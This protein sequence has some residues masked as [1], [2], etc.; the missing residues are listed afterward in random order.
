VFQ[1]S[2]ASLDGT[3]VFDGNGGINY[4]QINTNGAVLAASLAGIS[5][6]QFI[7]LSA[8]GSVTLA[9]TLS[10]TI[11]FVTGTSAA[12]TF[13]GSG[14][15]SYGISF[16]GFG[17]A[18]T[19]TG[20]AQ[21]DAFNIEDSAFTAID[22][23]AGIDYL[24]PTEDGQT[25]DISANAVKID[26]IEAI[27]LNVADNTTVSLVAADI[28]NITST[29]ALYVVGGADDELDA[30]TGWTLIGPHTN[31]A[32]APGVTFTEYLHSGGATLYVD[33]DITLTI[34][35]SENTPPT[36]TSMDILTNEDFNVEIC[37]TTFADAE[38]ESS[39]ADVEA[40]FNVAR[41]NIVAYDATGAIAITGSGTGT[42]TLT[43]TIAEINAFV[44]EDLITYVPQSNDAGIVNLTIEI[45]D[46]APGV[47]GTATA[48][49]TITIAP[50]TD[51]A[52]VRTGSPGIQRTIGTEP[53]NVGLPGDGG[54][55]LV[56]AV[57]D[58]TGNDVRFDGG[59]NGDE[60]DAHTAALPDGGFVM[61]WQEDGSIHGQV[62]G[63]N[64]D[65][66]SFEP[67]YVAGTVAGINYEPSVAVLNDGRFVVTWAEQSGTAV[68]VN[69]RIFLAGA[70]MA[71]AFAVANFTLN[72][73]ESIVPMPEVAAL[74]DGGFI[75]T[76]AQN[77]APEDAADSHLYTRSY[78]G[79]G[80]GAAAVERVAIDGQILN[81]E[82][83][84][85]PTGGFALGWE[86]I[87]DSTGV[88]ERYL[89][90]N[91]FNAAGTQV[92]AVSVGDGLSNFERAPT[93][94][95]FADGSVIGIWSDEQGATTDLMAHRFDPTGALITMTQILLVGTSNPSDRNEYGA[96]ATVLADGGLA[97]SWLT[98]TI[99]SNINDVFTQVFNA[100]LTPRGVELQVSIENPNAQLSEH[101]LAAAA[102]TDGRYLLSW[103]RPDSGL[104]PGARRSRIPRIRA[105]ATTSS[106]TF[107]SRAANSSR[108]GI[109]APYRCRPRGSSSTTAR[110]FSVSSSTSFPRA[111]CSR[112]ATATTAPTRRRTGWAPR[113]G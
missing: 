24:I 102:L 28:T 11:Q 67:F 29:N 44:A 35:A 52:V 87:P 21:K 51:G 53:S 101:D 80:N 98:P 110:S 93:L 107:S 74:S 31:A 77:A 76:W 23:N 26:D 14:V 5:D 36:V 94:A 49:Q 113:P 85:R 106:T 90:F 10:T 48:T 84:G 65:P 8:G 64:G 78:D 79:N 105:P 2:A 4:L 99:S 54:E 39:N 82:A 56:A 45:S 111:G 61:V 13:D 66:E 32:V 86:V 62:F 9:D 73:P 17:G 58:P 47:P 89:Q 38:A 81:T 12:D 69:G 109:S 92:G 108:A 97:V 37:D 19:L 6:V 43:G 57:V 72:D 60:S 7:G 3:D 103:I 16:Y 40:T 50:E 100:D 59:D 27:W 91:T 95:A 88:S 1:S 83:V 22:G 96:S 63:Q 68:E 112:S 15:S 42:L 104:G 18:D 30:G 20:G 70:A 75:V 25:L 71:D 34:G 33:N 41:G 55:L 46:L